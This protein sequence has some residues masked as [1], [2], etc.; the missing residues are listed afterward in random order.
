MKI[1]EMNV[2]EIYIE[3]SNKETEEL[4][5]EENAAFLEQPVSYLKKNINE[6]I[7]FETPNFEEINIDAISIE[8]DD[9]FRIYNALF[10]LKVKKKYEEVI[11]TYLTKQLNSDDPAKFGLMF[12]HGDGLWDINIALTY[13][14]GFN[15]DMSI[16]EAL[17][18]LLNLLVNLMNEIEK[19]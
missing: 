16:A 19:V 1:N 5:A 12:N 14:E 2:E 4:I 15:E 10:G 8:V 9:V 6:F 18:L 7:Y 13:I 17:N 11:A 3:R